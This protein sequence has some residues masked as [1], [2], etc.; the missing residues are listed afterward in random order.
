MAEAQRKGISKGCLIALAVVAVIVII[1]I[2]LTIYCMKNPGKLAAMA[3]KP[4]MEEIKKNLPEGYTEQDVDEVY[5]SFQSAVENQRIDET[6]L[7]KIMEKV[8]AILKEEG[9]DKEKA[10]ELLD[11]IKDASAD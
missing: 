6:E 4:A 8:Q 10:K 2:V 3:L 1:G 9:I 7:R 11:Y 5:Q